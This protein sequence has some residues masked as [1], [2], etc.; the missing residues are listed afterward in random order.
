M[1]IIGA[2]IDPGKN[3]HIACYRYALPDGVLYHWYFLV[4]AWTNNQLC[5]IVKG[6]G[7]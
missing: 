3:I 5:G 6:A 1:A 4:H 2:A 7:H